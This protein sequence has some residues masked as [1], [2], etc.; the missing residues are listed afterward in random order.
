MFQVE[1]SFM[2]V[3]GACASVLLGFQL[4]TEISWHMEA[5]FYT[6]TLIFA[7]IT[8]ILGIVLREAARI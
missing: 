7:L 4:Q 6:I 8:L 1:F 3:L 5:I 2:L